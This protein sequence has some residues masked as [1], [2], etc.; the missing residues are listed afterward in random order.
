M[1]ETF[2]SNVEAFKNDSEIVIESPESIPQ[3]ESIIEIE[4]VTNGTTKV[5]TR[6]ENDEIMEINETEEVLE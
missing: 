1:T 2:T 3:D 5:S 4:T 6:Q